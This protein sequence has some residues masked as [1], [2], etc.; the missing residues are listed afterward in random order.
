L[1]FWLSNTGIVLVLTVGLVVLVA[2]RG[3]TPA[4]SRR[5]QLLRFWAPGW[6]TFL[7]ANLVI[8]QPWNWDNT[9]LL[10]YWYLVAAIPLAWLLT[11]VPRETWL[12]VLAA[13]ATL[14]LLASGI[15]AELAGM[16]GRSNAFQTPPSGATATLAGP[17]GLTVAREVERRTS[18]RA[19]FLTEGQPNDPVTSLAGR[20]AVLGYYGW[21]WSYGQ[22]LAARYRAVQLM[23]AGCPASGRCQVGYLLARYRVAYVEFEPGDYNQISVNLAWYRSQHLPVVASAPGYLIFDVRSLWR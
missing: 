6:I 20:T 3:R 14:T 12:R 16:E 11:Q 17:A 23:Y 19:I 15:L 13:L 5:L 1:G 22:P 18:P 21:L 4:R 7:L 9:K 8:T 10:S 2:A